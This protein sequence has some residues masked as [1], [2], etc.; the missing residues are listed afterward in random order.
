MIM[1]IISIPD[2]CACVSG[3][4]RHG[5]E[6]HVIISRGGNGCVLWP[7]ISKVMNQYATG[8]IH[9]GVPDKAIWVVWGGNKLYIWT[10]FVE[11]S[12]V[13]GPFI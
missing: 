3:G 9:H 11:A 12:S 1:M 4:F 7:V 10:V 6:G 8:F 5:E 13:S 2:A